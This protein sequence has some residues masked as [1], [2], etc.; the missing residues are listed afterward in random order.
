LRVS[1][2][3]PSADC[4]TVQTVLWDIGLV[5][6]VSLGGAACTFLLLTAL[7]AR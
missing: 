5:L 7:G 2:P 6:A 4:N 3:L 1:A